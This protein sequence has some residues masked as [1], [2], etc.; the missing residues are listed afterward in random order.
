MPTLAFHKLLK[1]AVGKG[2]GDML[3]YDIGS[4]PK[5]FASLNKGGPLRT[6][7]SWS[8]FENMETEAEVILETPVKV[9]L[10]M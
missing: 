3:T 10:Q 7:W 2:H 8:A 9:T 1:K 6:G 5:P 4:K